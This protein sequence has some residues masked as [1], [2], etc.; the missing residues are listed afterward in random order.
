LL[1]VRSAS[2]VKMRLLAIEMSGGCAVPC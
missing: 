2:A 1:T